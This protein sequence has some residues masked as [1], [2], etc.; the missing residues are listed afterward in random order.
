MSGTHQPG[1]KSGA[2]TVAHY[3]TG[4][5]KWNPIEHSLLSEVSKN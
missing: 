1:H 3:P 5:S 4:G 2:V